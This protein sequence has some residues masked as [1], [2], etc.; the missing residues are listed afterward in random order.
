MRWQPA[1]SAR[2]WVEQLQ[3]AG[4]F[5]DPGEARTAAENAW[6]SVLWRDFEQVPWL[7]DPKHRDECASAL[8]KVPD[9]IGKRVMLGILGTP[10][11]AGGEPAFGWGEAVIRVIEAELPRLQ[12]LPRGAQRA[13]GVIPERLLLIR[14]SQ[15][16]NSMEAIRWLAQQKRHFLEQQL[17][18]ILQSDTIGDRRE[19][20]FEIL[21]GLVWL[22]DGKNTAA[23]KEKLKKLIA[24]Q[25]EGAFL[26]VRDYQD[27]PNVPV[28]DNFRAYLLSIDIG[29][30]FKEAPVPVVYF[31]RLYSRP[32]QLEETMLTYVEGMGDSFSESEA[33]LLLP[34][35]LTVD[36][37]QLPDPTLKELKSAVERVSQKLSDHPAAVARI[38]RI[39]LDAALASLI[40]RA[41]RGPDEPPGPPVSSAATEALA[42][43]ADDA[44]FPP[45]L[46]W[47]EL[48]PLFYQ[49]RYFP[50]PVME[51]LARLRAQLPRPPDSER[52]DNGALLYLLSHVP[53]PD[54]PEA[55]AMENDL[56]RQIPAEGSLENV[57]LPLLMRRADDAQLESFLARARMKEPDIFCSLVAAGRHDLARKRLENWPVSFLGPVERR[58]WLHGFWSEAGQE[59]VRAFT[60]SVEDPA[61]RMAAELVF[62]SVPAGGKAVTLRQRTL[63]MLMERMEEPVVQG[64]LAGLF[65]RT[66]ENLQPRLGN[67]EVIRE[68]LKDRLPVSDFLMSEDYD[69][70]NL[71]G[72]RLRTDYYSGNLQ[73]LRKALDELAALPGNATATAR[74]AY[75]LDGF[76][77][78]A[79]NNLRELSKDAAAGHQAREIMRFALT[80]PQQRAASFSDPGEAMADCLTYHALT[81]AVGELSTAWTAL[82]EATRALH[83]GRSDIAAR[84]LRFMPEPAPEVAPGGK[85]ELAARLLTLPEGIPGLFPGV[86]GAW[87]AEHRASPAP[88]LEKIPMLRGR[89]D[90]ASAAA[91]ADLLWLRQQT[92]GEKQDFG[93][94]LGVLTETLSRSSSPF[95][96]TALI[97]VATLKLRTLEPA[98]ALQQVLAAAPSLSPQKAVLEVSREAGRMMEAM[99]EADAA[100]LRK[101]GPQAWQEAA[102]KR[103]LE[104]PASVTR[105]AHGAFV[106]AGIAEIHSA[107]GRQTEALSLVSLGILEL[108]AAF[109]DFVPANLSARLTAAYTTFS[110]RAGTK[111]GIYPMLP[112]GSRWAVRFGQWQEMATAPLGWGD[113]KLTTE[114]TRPQTESFHL[115][116][117]LNTT[118]E[119]TTHDQDPE[120][121]WLIIRGTGPD[122]KVVQDQSL[123]LAPI[124]PLQGEAGAGAARGYLV[125]GDTLYRLQELSFGIAAPEAGKPFTFD[126]ALYASPLGFIQISADV[127]QR[128]GALRAAAPEFWKNQPASPAKPR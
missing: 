108:H 95:R 94:V 11:R 4:F 56:I 126:A 54:T 85:A 38:V 114:L 17:D 36:G 30:R 97:A 101:L 14:T 80:H 7:H 118:R 31:S 57:W 103:L 53:S 66:F 3:R 98:D 76:S 15:P 116:S 120:A 119:S 32:E 5:E 125:R 102:A 107:A 52:P 109:P 73:P 63:L 29:L 75:L 12:A 81:D 33:R 43:F 47:R 37:Q 87:I 106:L 60:A 1:S 59:R 40:E 77:T 21:T 78:Y 91:L 69:L 122:P 50:L 124:P 83:T 25:P 48:M 42:R 71:V 35:M 84:L 110:E 86:L 13:L 90:P 49:P 79:L 22:A 64:K 10:S 19:P 74:I 88:L 51:A 96:N 99:I 46:R 34:R 24:K 45:A 72:D 127:K 104:A 68:K 67:D 100:V 123:I 93:P 111:T 18:D 2:G 28:A 44:A 128:E 92:T 27:S 117:P 8:E 6:H 55:A 65:I 115:S 113:K 70:V 105:Q 112:F 16:G 62:A 20:A 23:L 121:C 89:K 61:R 82:P 26:S 39:A 9:S 58:E 41:E